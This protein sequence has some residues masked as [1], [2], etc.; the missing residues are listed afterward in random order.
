MFKAF[1]ASSSVWKRT[2]TWHLEGICSP[3]NLPNLDKPEGP[4]ISLPPAK[5][6]PSRTDKDNENNNTA[7][8]NLQR[9]SAKF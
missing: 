9:D 1:G 3:L 5:A 2:Q 4:G 8:Y 6:R 7:I